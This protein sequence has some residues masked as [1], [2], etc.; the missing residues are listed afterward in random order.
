[1]GGMTFPRSWLFLRANESV[2]VVRYG[3]GMVVMSIEGPGPAKGVHGFEDQS[4]AHDFLA[5]LHQKLLADSWTF[6]GADA[7]RR[8]VPDRR[9]TRRTS[10][11]RRRR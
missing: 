1:M 5:G 6:E 2:R 4:E 8:I 7:E 3:S 11:E 10:P 9:S